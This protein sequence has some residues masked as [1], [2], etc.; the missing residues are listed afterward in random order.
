MQ[1]YH[2]IK[3]QKMRDEGMETETEEVVEGD[4]GGKKQLGILIT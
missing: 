4:E 3:I 2:T 1:V